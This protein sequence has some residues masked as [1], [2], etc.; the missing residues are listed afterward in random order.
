MSSTK[1]TSEPAPRPGRVAQARAKAAGRRRRPGLGVE[2]IV[3]VAL[4]IIDAEG[5]SAVSMRRVA[6]EFDTGPASLYAHVENRDAL[7]RLALDRVLDEVRIPEGDD[8][9]EVVRQWVYD[10]RDVLARH[11]DIAQVS[12]AHIPSGQRMVETI[13]GL[14]SVMI[15]A[16]VPAK[17]ATWALDILAMYAAADAY[18][19]WLLGQRFAT[20]GRDAAEVGAEAFDQIGASFAALPA[21]KYPYLMANLPVLMSGGGEERFA[22]GVEMLL[23]G[24]AAQIK[25]G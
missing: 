22:F 3:D 18:E 16:G 6:A 20:P 17:V 24:I 10:S 14:L 9:L 1:R 13:E 21:E 23:A 4:R 12:F 15:P 19:G 2:A 11:G 8:W 7:L 5:T 25:R